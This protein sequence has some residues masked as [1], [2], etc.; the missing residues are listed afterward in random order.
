MIDLSL[1]GVAGAFIGVVAAAF[2]YGPLVRMVERW[3]R[4]SGG[5]DERDASELSLLWRAV[6]AADIFL[7]A[8]A[9]YWLA[10]VLAG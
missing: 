3:L 1:A 7:F 4:A 9:G 6:L 10:A 2:A 5:P 8:G